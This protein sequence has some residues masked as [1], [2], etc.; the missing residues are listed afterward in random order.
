MTR[1]KLQEW[2]TKTQCLW[3]RQFCQLSEEQMALIVLLT[4]TLFSAT[5]LRELH[6]NINYLILYTSAL[7]F[8]IQIK[9]DT[10]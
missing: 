10:S 3:D 8:K 4:K 6:K 5:L 2:D 7:H 1:K 9:N